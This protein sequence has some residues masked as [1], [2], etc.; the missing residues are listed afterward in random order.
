MRIAIM[1]TGGVGAVFGAR[2]A[3]AGEDVT[4]VARGK[5]KEAIVAGGL[6]IKSAERGDLLI[7]PCRVVSAF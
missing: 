7:K 5:H 1:G 4:F 3:H 6:Q 2:L